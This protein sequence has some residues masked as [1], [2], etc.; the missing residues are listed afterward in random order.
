LAD[1]SHRKLSEL[2]W[3]ILK[4]LKTVLSV[5][6]LLDPWTG[7]YMTIGSSRMPTKHVIRIHTGFVAC[8]LELR[9]VYDRVGETRETIQGAPALDGD[10]PTVG[11]EIL[12]ANGRYRCLCRHNVLVFELI[13]VAL[14]SDL[15]EQSSI[16]LCA[17]HGLKLNGKL[18]TFG[19]RKIPF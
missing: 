19:I 2:D 16:L 8:D 10:R 13:F 4:G 5:S 18:T 9:E 11:E 15:I 12:H 17:S 6:H 14:T 3:D 1:F 7:T